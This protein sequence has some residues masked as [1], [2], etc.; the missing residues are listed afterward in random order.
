MHHS[1]RLIIGVIALLIMFVI[2]LNSNSSSAA[3]AEVNKSNHQRNM[4]ATSQNPSA[5][6]KYLDSI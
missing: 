2:L 1:I 3:V 4:V 5:L 6:N